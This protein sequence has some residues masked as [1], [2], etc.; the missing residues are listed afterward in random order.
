MDDLSSP[1]YVWFYYMYEEYPQVHEE[2][3][4]FLSSILSPAIRGTIN[5]VYDIS[6]FYQWDCKSVPYL[7]SQQ[8]IETY[9]ED[10]V[11]LGIK[12][13]RRFVS[14]DEYLERTQLPPQ[15]QTYLQRRQ[16]EESVKKREWFFCFEDLPGDQ[17]ERFQIIRDGVWVDINS[18]FV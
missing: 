7:S 13:D 3:G 6:I 4:I 10:V 16:I 8:I 12:K 11:R 17:F 14:W 2:K 1:Q 5:D 9:F 18:V 15:R